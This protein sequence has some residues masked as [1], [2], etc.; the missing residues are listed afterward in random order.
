MFIVFRTYLPLDLV[1]SHTIPIYVHAPYLYKTHFNIIF[2]STIGLSSGLFQFFD[3]TFVSSY[4]L[5]RL[6]LS[7]YN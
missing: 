6:L 1:L 5:R 3:E 7:E 4:N 2:Q